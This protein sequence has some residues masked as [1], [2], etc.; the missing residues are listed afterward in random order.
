MS[1]SMS[2][3]VYILRFAWCQLFGGSLAVLLFL[4]HGILGAFLM[5]LMQFKLIDVLDVVFVCHWGYIINV[6]L[7]IT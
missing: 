4:V 5:K 2:F 6:V 3:V 1:E 7:R